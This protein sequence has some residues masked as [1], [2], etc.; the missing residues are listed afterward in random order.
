MICSD[1]EFDKIYA[2]NLTLVINMTEKTKQKQA[3]IVSQIAEYYLDARLTNPVKIPGFVELSTRLQYNTCVEYLH[4]N[5]TELVFFDNTKFPYNP[6]YFNDLARILK[7]SYILVANNGTMT[8]WYP[9][10]PK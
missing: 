4:N 2:G 5:R 7:D 6:E 10:A 9:K 1:D 3:L 8:A